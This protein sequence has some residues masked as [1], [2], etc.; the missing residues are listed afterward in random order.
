MAMRASLLLALFAG[1]QGLRTPARVAARCRGQMSAPAEVTLEVT[2][3]YETIARASE[4]FAR[5]FWAAE[6]GDQ[7]RAQLASKHKSDFEMRYGELTGKRRFPS[8]LL[9]A[10]DGEEILGCAGVEMT[11]VD[12]VGGVFWDR[13]QAETIFAER[14]GAMGGR[15][16]NLYRKALLPEL[17]AIFMEPGQAVRPVLSNLAVRRASRGT[18]LGERLVKGCED[19]VRSK[20]GSWAGEDLWLLVE[21]QNSPAVKLYSRLG[22]ETVW[23]SAHMATR[24]SSSGAGGLELVQEQTMLLAM[25]KKLDS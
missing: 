20:V 10:H 23:D 15:E 9:L 25:A 22:F 24:L 13:A 6:L 1:A 19:V 11:I 4:F 7:Q 2:S 17:A 18:G 21:E 3:D 8:A 5:E 16:R 14:L 12:P